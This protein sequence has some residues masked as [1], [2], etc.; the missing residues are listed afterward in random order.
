MPHLPPVLV[1]GLG[2]DI[3]SDD[4]IGLQIV[5]EVRRQLAD[6]PSIEVKATT[7]MGL[8]LLDEIVDRECLVLVD[9]VQTGKFP[10]GHIHELGAEE[11]R[12]VF[13]TS[14]HF[15]GVGETLRLAAQLGLAAP[16]HIRIFA[17]EVA[18][19]HTLST[20]LTPA[21]AGALAPAVA[22]VAAQARAYAELPRVDR[23]PVA[24]KPAASPG[25]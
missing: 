13:T 4:A 20:Q 19:P 17:V 3:L 25:D 24:V 23:S 15:L 5:T 9:S 16:R 18:D 2:N 1:L 14:P 6:A 21:V 7:E 12:T 10:P 22:R 8:A 11:L